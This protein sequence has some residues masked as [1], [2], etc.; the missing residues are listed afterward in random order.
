MS[1]SV[2]VGSKL[3][4]R[5]I[6]VLLVVMDRYAI[7][8]IRYLLT[9]LRVWQVTLYRLPRTSTAGEKPTPRLPRSP[10][11]VPHQ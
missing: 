9:V 11:A 5:N 8:Q 2:A 7:S 3:T 1:L 10:A 6:D 4:L